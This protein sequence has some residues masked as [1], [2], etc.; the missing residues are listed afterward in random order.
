MKANLKKNVIYELVSED[1]NHLKNKIEKLKKLAELNKFFDSDKYSFELSQSSSSNLKFTFDKVLTNKNFFL[2]FK[3]DPTVIELTHTPLS[4]DEF[5]NPLIQDLFIDLYDL[6]ENNGLKPRSFLGEN[7][8]NFSHPDIASSPL[9]AQN[10]IKD[11]FNFP[12]IYFGGFHSEIGYVEKVID[13][14]SKIIGSNRKETGA[15]PVALTLSDRK[16]L[17]QQFDSFEQERLRIAAKKNLDEIDPNNKNDE[18]TKKIWNSLRKNFQFK[19]GSFLNPRI[20]NGYTSKDNPYLEFRS[21]RMSKTPE[22]QQMMIDI[23]FAR[24]AYIKDL[25]DKNIV[26]PYFKVG[27]PS[28]FQQMIDQAYIYLEQLGLDYEIYK[29]VLPPI[30]RMKSPSKIAKDW[31]KIQKEKL[32]SMDNS[33][34]NTEKLFL[35]Y[36]DPKD[37]SH[38]DSTNEVMK[39]IFQMNPRDAE[40]WYLACW[41]FFTG[42]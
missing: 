7:H 41:L 35:D 38:Q 39:K 23:L 29:K 12:M 24:L 11:F 21:N 18:L 34:D 16:K 26:L 19:K 32:I 5:N 27:A 42:M 6:L 14:Q 9:F 40:P 31:V 37:S 28:S 15:M 20:A 1:E 4:E 13:P 10:L 3:I 22:L 36:V 8:L 30:W 25:S 33:I 2:N 17:V